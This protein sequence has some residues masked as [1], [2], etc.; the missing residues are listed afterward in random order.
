[1]ATITR[2]NIAPL[3]DKLT[4][5]LAKEDYYPSFEKSLKEYAK[6]ANIPGFRKGMVP[7]GLVKKMYGTS[8]FS[9]EIFRTVEKE[10]NHYVTE[11]KLDILGQPL[12]VNS[13]TPL[14]DV[15]NPIDYAFS[16][17]VGLKPEVHVNPNDIHVTRYKVNVTDAMID[18]EIGRLQTRNGKMVNPESVDNEENVLNVEL[19]EADE[20]G[21]DIEGGITKDTSLIVKYF[22]S[23]LRSQLMGKKVDDTLAIQLGKAFEDKERDWVMGDLA[24]DKN[25]DADAAKNFILTIKKIGMTEKSE[26]NEDFFAAVYPD[27]DIKT[28]QAFRDAVKAGIENAYAQQSSNQLHDQ[29]YHYITDHIQVELPDAFLKRWLQMNDEKGKSAEEVEAEYPDYTRQLLWSLIATKL[30]EDNQISVSPD[31]I[32][33][34]AKA[35]LMS[36]M[37]GQNFGDTSWMDDYAER[38][39]KD[40]KFVEQTYSQVQMGK[41]FQALE[42]QVQATEEPISVEDFAEKLHHHH[43]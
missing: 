36:Y 40:K 39:M 10:L 30:I 11:E 29:I 17:E 37:G 25:N 31:D 23:E 43:H 8:V 38:M 5:N 41:M 33:N 42:S 16:F 32:K 34:T 15:N 24:L 20:M 4:V 27:S 9:D 2:E 7:A 26:L 13:D 18:D 22:T 19:K 6:K 21:N 35:Q 12:P 28:E 3:T 1:M 14:P